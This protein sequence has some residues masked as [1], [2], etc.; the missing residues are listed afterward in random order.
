[1]DKPLRV[2]ILEDRPTDAD[3]MEFELQEA[4][5]A[6]ISKRVIS[7][8][9]FKRELV[10]FSPDLILSDYDLP[11]YTGFL[12][13]TEARTKCPDVPFILV[14]GAIGEDR[15][16]EI[17]T[18]GAKDYVMKSRLHRL[19][20][21][22]RRALAEADE[23]KARKEAEES[24]RQAH[25]N[26]E[27]EVKKRTA[28]LRAEI[29]ERKK[30]ENA[31]RESEERYRELVQSSPDAVI[32][33]R[34]GRFLFANPAALR[35]YGADSIDHLQGKGF[36]EL[37]HPDERA[38]ISEHMTKAAGHRGIPLQETMLI[39]LDGQVVP[40]EAVG[41]SVYDQGKRAMQIIIRD[42]TE[43][44]RVE[45]ALTAEKLFSDSLIDSL[46]SIFFVL[47]ED[48]QLVNWNRTAERVSGY[49]ADELAS[50]N[51][52]AV[53]SEE[54][55][56]LVLSKLR[57]GFAAGAA[58]AEAHLLTKDGRR[59]PYHLTGTRVVIGRKKYLIGTGIDATGA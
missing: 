32:V 24:L 46:P 59:V 20:P 18:H 57:E 27:A 3:L 39:R 22:V 52:L 26:L 5:F 36:L 54:D 19:V 51:L 2:L 41:T 11:Q 37:I 53:V 10:E 55:R 43:R 23:H 42:I 29:T 38:A 25:R 50:L 21:A 4:G 16:I 34:E 15:A 30:T 1:M 33:Q 13:L 17:L 47:R 40:V 12:A 7:E 48:G 31:L 45:E 8:D 14:T 56:G 44:K 58:S 28:E 35:L 49:S 6:F 9:A